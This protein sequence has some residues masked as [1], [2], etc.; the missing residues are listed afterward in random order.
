ML[1]SLILLGDLRKNILVRNNLFALVLTTLTLVI[2]KS[3]LY[4]PYGWVDHWAYLG[5]SNFLLRLREIYPNDPSGDLLPVIWPQYF[6]NL[7]F[8]NEVAVYFH[9]VLSLYITT[10][11]L[12]LVVRKNFGESTS[13]FIAS[14][15]VGSQYVLT[16]LGASYPTGSVV[17]Y[18]LVAIYFLQQNQKFYKRINP[19]LI[20]AFISFAL[21]FYSA[22]LSIIYLPALTIFYLLFHQNRKDISSYS[23]IGSFALHFIVTFLFTTLTLQLIYLSYGNG[24]FFFNNINKLLGFTVGNSYRAPEY[25]SWLPTATWL[26]LPLVI[27][28]VQLYIY[29]WKGRNHREYSQAIPFFAL[30]LITFAAQLFVNLVVH[31]W[32]LQFLYFNQALGIYFLGLSPLIAI[33]LK[34]LRNLGNYLVVLLAVCCSLIGIAFA[35]A[36]QFTALTLLENLPFSGYFIVH[37]L[38]L[39]I[40]VI[41]LLPVLLCIS[42]VKNRYLPVSL[43]I[44]LLINIFSFSPTFGCF[45]CFDAA[46]R[47]GIWPGVTS[48]S[49][50]QS[51]T[52]QVARLIDRVDPKRKSKIWY[53]ENEPLGPVFRQVN[54]ISYLNNGSNR[55]N[56][57]FP[58]F[59]EAAQPLGSEG[60]TLESGDQI[61]VLSSKVEDLNVLSNALK[62]V[63]L[64]AQLKSSHTL[65]FNPGLY[66]YFWVVQID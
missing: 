56:K 20:L 63:K 31:Q 39:A 40:V 41:L 13:Y 5:Q 4:N 28:A 9:G 62:S 14:M 2:N 7:I 17:L 58:N 6:L 36:K 52:L 37:P 3:W 29:I 55:V 22:I 44:L 1:V 8:P 64:N 49:Q 15:W 54:A 34:N 50:N 59:T 27:C 11:V 18:I 53:N 38:R 66:V 23:K 30:T 10:M 48:M 19:Y 21:A 16:S 42:F 51:S 47:F 12:I 60:S 46:S 33:P 25:S 45:A 26:I 35:N 24:F 65:E 57:S 61:L 43:S 32:S